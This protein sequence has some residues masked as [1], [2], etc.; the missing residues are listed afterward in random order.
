MCFGVN[1]LK[2]TKAG[3]KILNASWTHTVLSDR[4]DCGDKDRHIGSQVSG[5]FKAFC[6]TYWRSLPGK[7]GLTGWRQKAWVSFFSATY[8]HVSWLWVCT[9]IKSVN[10]I[11][12]CEEETRSH[13][14]TYKAWFSYS[15]AECSKPTFLSF[16]FFP[17][18][19]IFF[20]F[21]KWS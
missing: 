12:P 3:K 16:C 6:L 18:S 7:I 15:K 13:S 2:K 9:I 10:C 21:L 19:Q 14:F 20:R 8:T 1:S 4:I 17:R 5:S 11:P